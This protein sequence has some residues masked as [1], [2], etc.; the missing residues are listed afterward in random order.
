[1][2]RDN[3]IDICNTHETSIVKYIKTIEVASTGRIRQ[4]HYDHDYE[5]PQVLI[6]C[7]SL[8]C[9]FFHISLC[10]SHRCPLVICQQH[11]TESHRS[12]YDL[13]RDTQGRQ[14][15]DSD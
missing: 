2:S 11:L 1:M 9:L 4:L 10:S 3:L 15:C 5:G 7:T 8:E 13:P 6:S 12:D 14:K